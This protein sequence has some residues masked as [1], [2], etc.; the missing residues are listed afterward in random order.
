MTE[1][2]E[3]IPY[4]TTAAAVRGTWGQ[5]GGELVLSDGACSNTTAAPATTPLM[6]ACPLPYFLVP[7]AGRQTPRSR[8]QAL[9]AARRLGA[10]S[11]EANRQVPPCG[12]TSSAVGWWA[13]GGERGLRDPDPSLPR[14]VWH[15]AVRR[16]ESRCGATGGGGKG[17]PACVIGYAEARSANWTTGSSGG[18]ALGAQVPWPELGDYANI[19]LKKMN[20]QMDKKINGVIYLRSEVVQEKAIAEM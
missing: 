9:E 14:W 6:A 11:V 10:S 12:A 8:R 5:V 13:S 20:S 3:R 19:F 4:L 2:A 15:Q 16:P 7:A 17:G 1:S 18:E